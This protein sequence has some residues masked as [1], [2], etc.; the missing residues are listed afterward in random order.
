MV[1]IGTCSRWQRYRRQVPM[2][3]GTLFGKGEWMHN[4]EDISFAPTVFLVEQPPNY[5]VAT[6]FHRQNE[7]QVVVR[8]SGRLGPHPIRPY[9][10]HYAGA[11]TGY[12]PLVSGPEGLAY[13][14]LRTAFDKGPLYPGPDRAALRRGPKRQLHT[15]PLEIIEDHA[16]ASLT[17]SQRIDL[18]QDQPDQIEA[19]RLTLAPG[20]FYSLQCNERSG[21]RFALVLSGAV[22]FELAGDPTRLVRWES[23]FLKPGE[24]LDRVRAGSCGADLLLMQLAATDPAYR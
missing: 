22:T 24:R 5:S 6:H 23:L 13:F 12:G 15:G 2:P 17:S 20:T 21:G 18:I 4:G 19:A 7:F 16:I 9:S 11:Y 8:G 14:T 1:M 3:D 10:V